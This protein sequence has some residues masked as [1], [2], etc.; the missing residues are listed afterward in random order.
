MNT[1]IFKKIDSFYLLA[2]KMGSDQILRSFLDL[3]V[4]I[5]L[6]LSISHGVDMNHLTEA[7][8]VSS[9]EPIH[10][11]YNDEIF[12]RASLIKPC[13]K[14]PHPWT[15]LADMTSSI[16][17][18]KSL[19]IIGPPAGI[20]NDMNLLT[21]LRKKGIH[22]GDILIKKRGE[23]S[24][25]EDFWKQEGF[26]IVSAGK[27]DSGFYKRL[28]EVISKYESI[29]SCSMSSA[30]I[31]AASLGKKCSVVDDFHMVTYELADFKNFIN[32]KGSA[33]KEF[34]SI[35]DSGSLANLQNF[36]QNLLGIQYLGSP[37][38]MKS[39]LISKLDR[40]DSPI[41]HSQHDFLITKK[42]LEYISI[43]FNKP[44]LINMSFNSISKK[45]FNPK[46]SVIS[47]NEISIYKH[48]ISNTNFTS[49][50]ISY[51][52]GV[53]EPGRAID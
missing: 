21:S 19:L 51:I 32:F 7:Q 3:E 17:A 33:A 29:L 45:I 14:I 26:G 13:I 50:T 49:Q 41:H 52:S 36:S 43:K 31:F 20:T 35:L 16:E 15:I 25:S 11:C 10:W 38:S 6:P 47:K 46:V 9:I 27:S 39:K 5:S 12:A 40:I 8:D 44:S 24:K 42:L 37:A 18:Q 4:S 48:G 22:S 30:L 2:K 1:H 28:F 23:T 34:L 53:T